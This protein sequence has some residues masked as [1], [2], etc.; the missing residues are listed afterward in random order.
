MVKFRNVFAW[1]QFGPVNRGS[2][3]SF[4][5]DSEVD[6]IHSI[7]DKAMKKS[8]KIMVIQYI[9]MTSVT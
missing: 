1:T 3:E 8:S 2:G 4:Q 5:S 6:M 9:D 7:L